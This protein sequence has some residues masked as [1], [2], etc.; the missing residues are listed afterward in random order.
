ML[1][2][3]LNINQSIFSAFA[4]F[5]YTLPAIADQLSVDGLRKVDDVFNKAQR[6]QPTSTVPNSA[7][8]YKNLYKHLFKAALNPTHCW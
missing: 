3:G 2:K 6:W 1:K 5:Q 8:L 4:R 7:G